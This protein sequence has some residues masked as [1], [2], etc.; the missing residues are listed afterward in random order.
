[1]T[2]EERLD[3]FNDVAPIGREVRYF[4][5]NTE[6]EESELKAGQPYSVYPK[7][8]KRSAEATAKL[9][10]TTTPPRIEGPFIRIQWTLL[11][12][13]G[14]VITLPTGATVPEEITLLQLWSKAIESRCRLPVHEIKWGRHWRNQREVESGKVTELLDNDGV[15]GIICKE[16]K[17]TDDRLEVKYTIG[18]DATVFTI[19]VR[20]DALVG[21]V[22]KAIAMAHPSKPIMS[23]ASE[24]AD[25]ADEDPYDEGMERTGGGLRQIQAKI[26]PLVKVLLDYQGR[27]QQMSVRTNLSRAAFI[28]EVQKFVRTTQPLSAR[29]LGLDNWEIRDGT[30]YV[31]A[32]PEKA[33]LRCT[34]VDNKKFTIEI[35]GDKD[36]NEVCEA[37]QI[38]LGLKPWIRFT[39][40]RADNQPFFI[41]DGDEYL[42]VT[43]YD[44]AKDP[45]AEVRLRID[46]TDRTF[47]IP[48]VRIDDDPAKIMTMLS[49]NYGIAKT[50][51]SQVRFPT[52]T[53]WATGQE[54]IIAFKGPSSC[55]NVRL[56]PYT[57]RK[58]ILHIADDPLETD[59]VILPTSLK[60]A[61]IWEHLQAMYSTLIPDLS[62]FNIFVGHLDITK[63]DKWP[64]GTID[65]IPVRF[66][67]QWKI[68][69]PQEA[70]GFLE[71][72]QKEMTPLVTAMEAWQQLHHTVPRLY[73]EASL[74]YVGKLKPGAIITASI[75]RAEVQLAI[76][77]ELYKKATI[78][79]HQHV[80]N[81]ETWASIHAHFANF[82]TRIPPYSCYIEEEN[83]PYYPETT[84]TFRLKEGE[85]PPDTTGGSGG[86]AG[87]LSREGYYLPPIVFPAPKIDITGKTKMQGAEP[88]QVGE[89]GTD[90]TSDSEEDSEWNDIHKLHRIAQAAAKE[91][92][93]TIE[94]RA[95]YSWGGHL[96]EAIFSKACKNLEP[97][98][99]IGVPLQKA[100]SE[101]EMIGRT[102]RGGGLP[103]SCIWTPKGLSK[104]ELEIS[105][106]KLGEGTHRRYARRI[107]TAIDMETMPD[108][109]SVQLLNGW[110]VSFGT[111][112]NAKDGELTQRML[113]I[114]YQYHEPTKMYMQPW[115]I[116]LEATPMRVGE[117]GRRSANYLIPKG[118]WDEERQ[119]TPIPHCAK[120]IPTYYEALRGKETNALLRFGYDN[121]WPLQISMVCAVSNENTIQVTYS[122]NWEGF[123]MENGVVSPDWWW[124]KF[125]A[126]GKEERMTP[127]PALTQGGVIWDPSLWKE[128][129]ALR[130]ILKG[131][132]V[133]GPDDEGPITIALFGPEATIKMRTTGAKPLDELQAVL[134]IMYQGR[135]RV[136]EEIPTREWI[137]VAAIGDEDRCGVIPI[138]YRLPPLETTPS[139]I[140]AV[141]DRILEAA[142][143]TQNYNRG[144]D[145]FVR[146][147]ENL[148]A[149]SATLA[150]Q[151]GRQGDFGWA[152]F[153]KQGSKRCLLLDTLDGLTD[154]EVFWTA[155]T[156]WAIFKPRNDSPRKFPGRLYYPDEFSHIV[157]KYWNHLFS[158]LIHP[159][160]VN[161]TPICK[162][163]M[164]LF[165]QA[166]RNF[167]RTKNW[168]PQPC[169]EAPEKG[170]RNAQ[171]AAVSRVRPIADG[172]N[173]WEV[174]RGCTVGTGS[175]L[176]GTESSPTLGQPDTCAAGG[177]PSLT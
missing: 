77:F 58:F 120:E 174:C 116:R 60:K 143:R 118:S 81:M 119:I 4:V 164:T 125:R 55:I 152:I 48:K 26:V 50:S 150:I 78:T 93:L 107:S 69:M 10:D 75:I 176:V 47:Y 165:S 82:D 168:A 139:D 5:S 103:Y 149:M 23:L 11:S 43:T 148:E 166:L 144:L 25:L 72:V 153:M 173:Q 146:K 159:D 90:S 45:R 121:Q 111:S 36:L 61:E 34:D 15:E 84:I 99:D 88:G 123:R 33:T 66:P 71:V 59:E 113:Y 172:P 130:V 19:W 122:V 49:D 62:Q 41:E 21:D 177:S 39:I 128:N 101:L 98:S 2:K 136:L 133:W 170:L 70:S 18:A 131:G 145:K 20:S 54:V 114:T 65:A 163:R 91:Q 27:Q 9:T 109:V 30:T 124:S 104:E 64:P 29:P 6:V 106:L 160:F 42:V 53:P 12:H 1:M 169:A 147:Y 155:L 134:H 92:F 115:Q 76:T 171:E 37:C 135:Y 97:I 40:K 24:G 117:R 157:H 16:K 126:K 51:A 3:I 7:K 132:Q 142:L 14:E 35:E 158:L 38:Q 13:T 100:Y 56:E 17:K 32:S 112:E 102:F 105:V 86:A 89:S 129:N 137:L 110:N 44:P 95:E 31:I 67:V 96:H 63:N 156:C 68:E 154:E 140:R 151:K 57:R 162:E 52:P 46:L 127:P 94:I 28:T 87:G 85:E 73:E 167:K 80:P 83:R 79:Y 175:P 138:Q 74:D 22:K 161:E 108:Q 8:F 141:H